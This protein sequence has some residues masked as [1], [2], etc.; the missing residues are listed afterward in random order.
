MK[1]LRV[2]WQCLGAAAVFGASALGGSVWRSS[3]GAI[4]AEPL[5]SAIAFSASDGVLHRG[6]PGAPLV[7]VFGDYECPACRAFE[8]GAGKVL[9][10]LAD[11]GRIQLV[12]HDATLAPHQW[13]AAAVA[14][15]HCVAR[16][17]AGWAAH[18]AL[19]RRASEWKQADDPP[20][21]IAAIVL[22]A[23]GVPGGPDPGATSLQDCMEDASTLR[24]LRAARERAKLAGIHEVPTVI[25]GGQRLRFTSH[26]GLV[27]HITARVATP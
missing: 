14:A 4:R 3:S 11:A 19:Y 7:H 25:A 10:D 12:L 2:F 26:R 6:R 24:A 13:G 16:R 20:A 21:M 5:G 1:R 22:G 18:D 27:G 8:A 15:V 9:R 23:T 17:G